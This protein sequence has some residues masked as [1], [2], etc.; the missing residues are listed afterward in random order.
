M[1]IPARSSH[2]SHPGRDQRFGYG[3]GRPSRTAALAVAIGFVAAPARAAQAQREESSGMNGRRV[4]P[5]TGKPLHSCEGTRAPGVLEA[6][7]TD[8]IDRAARLGSV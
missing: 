4:G 8:A 7:A 2:G 5:C 6:T 1:K 3:G